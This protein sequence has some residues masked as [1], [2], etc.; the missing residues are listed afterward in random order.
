MIRVAANKT[1][2]EQNRIDT[3]GVRDIQYMT[4][5]R[6]KLHTLG[7]HCLYVNFYIY[8]NDNARKHNDS[9]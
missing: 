7:H 6:P 8:F 5:L 4:H 9:R 3:L 2:R 1:G